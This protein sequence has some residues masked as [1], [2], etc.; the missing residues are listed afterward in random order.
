[1]PLAEVVAWTEA[2]N[3]MYYGQSSDSECWEPAAH[4]TASLMSAWGI[5]DAP[6]QVLE[7]IRQAIETGYATALEH[8]RDGEYDDQIEMWWPA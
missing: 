1:L 6:S 2:V 5:I 4:A 7:M 8:V 3:R